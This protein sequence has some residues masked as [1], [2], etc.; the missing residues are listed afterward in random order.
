MVSRGAAFCGLVVVQQ[1]PGSSSP[2]WG[3]TNTHSSLLHCSSTDGVPNQ[4]TFRL[5]PLKVLFQFSL[6]K[7]PEF[8]LHN[9]Q[10]EETSQCHLDQL[11]SPIKYLYIFLKVRVNRIP[12]NICRR[13][14][15][16]S[17]SLVPDPFPLRVG[18]NWS[19]AFKNSRE[20][21]RGKSQL[22]RVIA[23]QILLFPIEGSLEFR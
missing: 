21:R 4:L 12:N 22:Y 3:R 7:S 1:M 18:Y 13:W 6:G 10:G 2:V 15:L 11:R 14:F 16:R 9:L 23:W 20:T 8:M 5:L 19:L 17:Q